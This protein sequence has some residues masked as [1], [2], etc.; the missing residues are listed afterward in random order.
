MRWRAI[1]AITIVLAL[2]GS[3]T[4]T[5]AKQK[6]RPVTYAPVTAVV[7]SEVS[8]HDDWVEVA[9]T[10]RKHAAKLGDLLLSDAFPAKPATSFRFAKTALLPARGRMMVAAAALHFKV[11]CG[12]DAVYLVTN[13]GRMLD[14]TQVP[15]LADQ[16][17]WSR[18]DTGWAPSLATPNFANLPAPSGTPVDRAAWIYDPFRESSIQLTVLQADIDRLVADPRTYVPAKFQMQDPTGKWWPATGPIDIGVRVKGS[19]GSRTHPM[20]GPGGLTIAADKVSLKLKFDFVDKGQR[21]FGL[22][23]L[24]LNSMIQDPILVQETL[25]YRLFREAGVPAPRT[26]FAR[27][28][29]NGAYRGLYLSLEATDEIFLAWQMQDAK[30]LYE[31]QITRLPDTATVHVIR[32]DLTADALKW[33]F[34]LDEG[35]ANDTS[36][37]TALVHA[38]EASNP[39][40]TATGLGAALSQRLDVAE[41]GR[42][43]AIEKFVNH[44]DGYS[45]SVPWGPHNFYLVSDARG[46]FR[47][48]PSGV[49][50]TW[51]YQVGEEG[52]NPDGSEPFDSG[53]GMLMAKCVSDPSC[54]AAYRNTLAYAASVAVEY[55][56]LASQLMG[57]HMA[58]RI[59]DTHRW[60]PEAWFDGF[61]SL[62][63]AYPEARA[64]QVRAYLNSTSLATGH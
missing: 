46:V 16:L 1:S 7:L 61:R 27:V 19:V 34:M 57:L 51:R 22:R 41:L 23:K 42:F 10:D 47:F 62:F 48:I 35:D 43:L 49:D 33:A 44:W 59:G 56:D 12:A 2:L 54:D 36:D 63:T 39:G 5:A 25:S 11:A 28:E 32:P 53:K 26:G 55:R 50:V 31:G 60:F 17:T 9:N 45:G 3:T 13:G 8:C 4:A 18:F 20:Y 6:P 38:A 15:N 52:L 29:I 24:T 21:F 14:R 64:A 40:E 37:L 58:S 30:H